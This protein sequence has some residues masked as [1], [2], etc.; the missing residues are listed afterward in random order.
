[1]VIDALVPVAKMKPAPS[2]KP[3]GP[4]IRLTVPIVLTEVGERML[5]QARANADAGG[6]QVPQIVKQ[7]FKPAPLSKDNSPE[8]HQAWQ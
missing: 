5:N 2:S 3:F 4:P 1:M 7:A 8:N 6:T